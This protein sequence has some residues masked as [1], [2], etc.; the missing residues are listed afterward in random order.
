[1]AAYSYRDYGNRVGIWRILDV[2]GAHGIRGSVALN[3]A[4]CEHH[5]EI[6]EATVPNASA[7]PTASPTSCQFGSIP[8]SPRP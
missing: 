7:W 4:L 8:S 2:L 6:V 1:V 3:A 5:P